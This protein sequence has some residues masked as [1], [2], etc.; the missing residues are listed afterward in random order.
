MKLTDAQTVRVGLTKRENSMQRLLIGCA[1]GLAL[2]FGGVAPTPVRHIITG[3]TATLIAT[4]ATITI[5]AT[6]ATITIIATTAAITAIATTATTT[7]IA[8][9]VVTI[10]AIGNGA[11]YWR[12]DSS[13]PRRAKKA[14]ACCC[15]LLFFGNGRSRN[16]FNVGGVVWW[17][18]GLLADL[19]VKTE[20]Q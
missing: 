20:V 1:I 19:Q 18:T 15:G 16:A 17:G 2:L 12:R 14:A 7:I 13:F 9:T 6:T 8:S 11:A 5:I 10:I 3:T 4:T